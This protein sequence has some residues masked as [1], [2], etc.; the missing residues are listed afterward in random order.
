MNKRDYIREVE[1]LRTPDHLRRR[2]VS[3]PGRRTA[4]SFRWGRLLSLAACLVLVIALAVALP[5][6]LRGLYPGGEIVS[7][8]VATGSD[9]TI[10]DEEL[11]QLLAA[12]SPGGQQPGDTWELLCS[13]PGDG[14]TLGVLRYEGPHAFGLGSLFVGV[15]DNRTREPVEPVTIINGDDGEVYTWVDIA[16]QQQYLLCTNAVITH[17]AES[18]TAALFTF[19]GSKLSTVTELPEVALGAENLPQGAETMF[20]AD[21][22]F[23][24]DHKSVINGAGLDLYVRNPEWDAASGSE[25]DQWSYLCYVPLAGEE[26]APLTDIARPDQAEPTVGFDSYNPPVLPLVVDGDSSNLRTWRKLTVDFTDDLF[27]GST[28]DNLL[29][30]PR[31]TDRYVV[32]NTSG[33]DLTVTLCYPYAN[34]LTASSTSLPSITLDGYQQDN[35]PLI[36]GSLFPETGDSWT[37]DFTAWEDYQDAMDS[38][39][40]LA[41]AKADPVGMLAGVPVTVYDILP[42]QDYETIRDSL[43]DPWSATLAVDCTLSDPDIQLFVYGLEGYSALSEDQLSRRYSFS[44]NDNAAGLHRIIVVGGTLEIGPVTGYTDGS[45]TQVVTELTG[46]VS[47]KENLSLSD[48]LLGCVEDFYFPISYRFLFSPPL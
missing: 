33:R 42:S 44:L 41:G 40:A 5:A 19:D 18:C 25:D 21:T 23:W 38:G 34:N 47:A 35:S 48:A 13:I 46:Q 20:R 17:G 7:P 4:R 28:A 8:P 37:G 31:V 24:E 15:F 16:T 26:Q 10:P 2:I 11:A 30:Y 1:S 22:D 36:G 32:E 14:R 45:C 43:D 6:L 39:D 12:E 29:Y 3:L 9:D 27:G